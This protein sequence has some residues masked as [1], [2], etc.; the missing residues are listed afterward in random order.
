VLTEEGIV[1]EGNHETLMAQK[2][3]YHEFYTMA[4]R[5]K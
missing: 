2:G 4:D 5:M 1:E 3:I